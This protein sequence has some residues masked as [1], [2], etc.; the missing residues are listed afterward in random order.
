M[1]FASEYELFTVD[2]KTINETMIRDFLIINFTGKNDSIGLR[3]NN[4]FFIKKLQTNIRNNG[5][6]VNNIFDFIKQKN[7]NI[8][9]NFSV[10]VNIGP[11][12]FS[13]IRISL[14]IAKGIKIAKGTKIYGYKN[15]DLAKFNLKNIELLIQKNLIEN[16]L[17]KP[18]YLS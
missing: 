11:G 3:V 14:A 1:L 9:K 18:V 7:V 17:I 4:N 12:S 5:L 16:N 2:K 6:L 10:I 8:N 13:G 15:S